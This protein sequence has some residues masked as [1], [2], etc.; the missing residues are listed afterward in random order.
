MHKTFTTAQGVW[1]PPL[2]GDPSLQW[3]CEAKH[4]RFWVLSDVACCHGDG[5]IQTTKMVP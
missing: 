1:T 3:D 5:G 2:T 4:R